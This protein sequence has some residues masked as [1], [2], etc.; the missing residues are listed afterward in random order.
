MK[1]SRVSEVIDHV[2]STTWPA[3]IWGPPGVGKSSI[4]RQIAQKRKLQLLD[5][6]ASLLDPTDLRG[7]PTVADNKAFWCPPSFLPSDPGSEGILFFDELNAAPP[8]VQAS[9]YQLTLDRRVGEYILPRKW[10]ILAAGNRAEDASVTFRMPAA[11]SNRFIHLDY[12]VDFEDWR[13]WALDKE[14]QPLVVGFLSMRQELL[15][16][17]ERSDKGFPTPRSWEMVSDMLGALGGRPKDAQ[18]ILIGIIGEGAAIEF[19]AY[20]DNAMSE[21]AIKKILDDPENATLPQKLGDQYALIS[22]VSV[23]AKAPKTLDAAAILLGRFKPE[24]AVLLL[25]NILQK[26]PKFATNKKVAEF[27]KANKDLIL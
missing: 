26:N 12:E 24:L 25:R 11:L 21:E 20:C 14:I 15:F 5:I 13:K 4:V 19:M 10:K 17:M 22:Y 1:P 16:N 27:I 8:L 23:T 7:I 3:F 6:R 2:L 9:L 18:D